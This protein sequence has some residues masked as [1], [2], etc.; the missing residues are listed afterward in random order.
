MSLKILDSIY[1]KL[2]YFAPKHRVSANRDEF[3]TTFILTSIVNTPIYLAVQ[4]QRL[5]LQKLLS[6]NKLWERGEW[7]NGG[8]GEEETEAGHV[9][10]S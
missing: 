9:I 7:E 6:L 5:Q 3:Q 8:M 10:R 1:C 2:E 4:L